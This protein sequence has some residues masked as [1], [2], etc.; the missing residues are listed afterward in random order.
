M[1]L[2]VLFISLL[3]IGLISAAFLFVIKNSSVREE[4]FSTIVK[5]AYKLRRVWMLGLCV[6]GVAVTV[7]TLIPFPISAENGNNPK[8]VNAVGGQWYWQLDDTE[9]VVG[10]PIQFHVSSNDVNHG[11]AIYNPE[12]RIVAQ[13]QGMPGY[14]NKLNVTF[15]EPGVY[16]ILCLEYCGLAHHAMRVELTVAEAN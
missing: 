16:R 7:G 10:E 12:H 2:F 11:F 3:G 9:F 4:D 1:Q 13:T 6:L 5:P 15:D 8:I 14:T